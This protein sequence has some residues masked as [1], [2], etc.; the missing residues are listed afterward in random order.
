MKKTLLLVFTISLVISLK[1]QNA[2]K[3][4]VKDKTSGVNL[5]GVTLSST[6]NA[7]T[8]A[9][10]DAGGIAVVSNLSEADSILRFSYVGYKT[11][12]VRVIG[13]TITHI[14]FMEQDENA[15][16]K[17]TVVS[18][19]RNNDPVESATTKVEVLGLEE[20]NDEST[21]KP[22]NIASILGD[23]SGIQIQQS[24][25]TSGN[26]NVR[27]QGLE[28]KYTQ[29]LRDGMPLYEGY[30]GGFG[31]LSIPPLDLKQ[32]ELIKGAAST[33]YGGGAIAGLINLVSK[34]PSFSP[35]ASF[36]VNQ[37][38]LKETNINVY[39]A[40]R[41][42]H[43]GFT[44]FAGQNLQKQV[45]V[46]KDG[47]SDVP[48]I[49]STILHPTLF[50]YPT[51]KSYISLS[52]SGSFD[53]RLGG[54]MLAIEG[55][56]DNTHRYYEKN[57]FSR[58]TFTL[59]TENRFN[60]SLSATVKASVSLFDRDETTNTYFFSGK[61][62]NFYSEASLAAHVG[63]HNLVG[64]LNITGDE[65]KPS[66]ATPAPVGKFSNT[67]FGAFLQDTWKLLEST[68][69]ETGLRVDHHVDY[70]NFVL[71]RIALFHHFNEVWGARL[72][73]GMGYKTP[74]PLTQQI[75][76]YDI[77]SI[78]PISSAVTAEKSVG[79]NVEVNYKK[80]FGDGN[81]FFINH[82][83]FITNIT[84]PIVATEDVL[85]KVSFTN[86]SKPIVTKGFDTYVQMEVNH[87]ELY[88]GYTYTD[89][90]RNYLQQNNFMLLTP[91]HRAASVIAYE[92]EHNWRFGL[93]GSY[94]GQQYRED[95]S[96][97]PGYAFLAAMIEKKLGPKW[98]LVLNCEN[99]L[100]ERQSKYERLYT[101]SISTPS[102]RSLWAP[103][104]GRVANFSVRF[105]PFEKW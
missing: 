89:A 77:Y 75:K 93:E 67:T 82:A 1:A 15:L 34:K 24:S 58:N 52:W 12:E 25:V 23:M 51:D 7:K 30:S 10:S 14:I 47:F 56:S 104:D 44:L 26:S 60:S 98:S 62:N 43:A 88:L 91:R 105:K 92:I 84:D 85:G 8:N 19:T 99:L 4:L 66:S 2:F 20:M 39:Y 38:T 18:S 78:Q 73:F 28:G 6:T 103:I 86:F 59:M 48:D 36:L 79:A 102:F 13:D 69:I 94:T 35:D 76:D 64:G 11:I 31:I 9:T 96:K 65:F 21:L 32:I 87:W 5:Q 41:W 53:K 49:K 61:Q 17:V 70:G 37:T 101:G 16:E 74:N 80:E 90:K 50:I 81:T 3:V 42:K 46:D 97:T 22:G 54:D 68:K 63:Q 100:D 83:F 33:L 27:I 45:D 71:P 57:K 29:I 72:G 40:Q 55:K 95:Y